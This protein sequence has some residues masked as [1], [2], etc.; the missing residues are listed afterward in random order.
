M[1]GC[2][3]GDLGQAVLK[4]G[5]LVSAV[6]P[7]DFGKPRPAVIVQTDRVIQMDSVLV[8]PLT[9]DLSAP[10]EFRLRLQPTPANGLTKTSDVMADKLTAVARSKCRNPIG[11]LDDEEMERLSGL[12]A[13]LLGFLD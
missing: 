11:R 13:V 2:G 7:G 5:D 8:A 4:R 10:F 3:S 6:L 1:R 9:S 12:L